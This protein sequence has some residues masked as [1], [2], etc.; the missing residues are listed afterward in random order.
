V[1]SI[2]YYASILFW[3]SIMESVFGGLVAG[4]MGGST[5]SAGLPHSALM[6][7]VTFAF[8]NVLGT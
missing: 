5:L 2:N 7:T 3:A 6:I 4:K 1:L 8:F